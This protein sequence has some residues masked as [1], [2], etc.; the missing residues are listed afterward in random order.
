MLLCLFF[1]F[2][3]CLLL[4]VCCCFFWLFFFNLGVDINRLLVCNSIYVIS[5]FNRR[6]VCCFREWNLGSWRLMKMKMTYNI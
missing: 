3:F 4:F 2:W 1:V 6:F 5:L